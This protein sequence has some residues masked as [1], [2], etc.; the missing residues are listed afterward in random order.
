MVAAKVSNREASGCK[1]NP[2]EPKG[3][4]SD[5]SLHFSNLGRTSIPLFAHFFCHFSGS[6]S[7]SLSREAESFPPSALLRGLAK[8]M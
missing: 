4:A 2:C 5:F 3:L 1:C 7:T 6:R 8:K